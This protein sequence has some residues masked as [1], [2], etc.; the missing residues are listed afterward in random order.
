M[1]M[2][3][4]I[5]R[6]GPGRRRG[7]ARSRALRE[8]GRSQHAGRRA[9]A[10][11][12]GRGQRRE[13]VRP[14]RS[15]ARR[16]ELAGRGERLPSGDRIS[17]R[18]RRRLERAGL[19]PAQPGPL[20]RVARRLRRGPAASPRV[21]RGA[22]VSRRGVRE[23]GT[24][25]RRPA[26]ARSAPHLSTR[27]A[28]ASSP[29]RSPELRLPRADGPSSHSHHRAA[30]RAGRARNGVRRTTRLETASNRPWL[31]S[32]SHGAYGSARRERVSG[33]ALRARPARVGYPLRTACSAHSS[34]LLTSTSRSGTR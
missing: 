18:L 9:A 12:S 10:P 22:R 1:A 6:P 15:R 5:D 31:G 16:E 29:R 8:R 11:V 32:T 13:R 28:P 30:T 2:R 33:P 24:P 34:V 19:R 20:P 27:R 26:R 17:S 3:R 4:R 23:D 21:P 14:R 25:R 7:R